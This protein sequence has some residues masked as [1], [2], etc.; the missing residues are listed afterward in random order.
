LHQIELVRLCALWDG[1]DPA[2][3]NVPTIVELIDYPG[4][5]ETLAQETASH[6]EGKGGQILFN[7]PD[8]DPAL[9]AV[10]AE[11][12]ARSEKEFGE[13]QAQ[14][15][16]ASLRK[17]IKDARA[18]VGSARLQGIMNLRDKH[19]AHSLSQTRREQKVGPIAPMKYGDERAILDDTLPIVEALYCWVNGCSFSFDDSREID[20]RNAKALW[21]GCKFTIEY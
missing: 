16:C 12:L 11:A 2:K 14:K 1:I 15:A 10:A 6:W 20:R 13:Q 19:L 18:V 9:Q 21:E 8:N 4:V 5:V 17:A 7:P 3:E